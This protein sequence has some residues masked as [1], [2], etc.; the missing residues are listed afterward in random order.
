MNPLRCSGEFGHGQEALTEACG[1]TA[2]RP[3]L[4][5]KRGLRFTAC[6][7]VLFTRASFLFT[8]DIIASSYGDSRTRR[9]RKHAPLPLH[10]GSAVCQALC[11]GICPGAAEGLG[12]GRVRPRGT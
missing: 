4:V 1:I 12:S 9:T 2:P 11:R 8:E 6:E 3:K 10:M 7:N 5:G